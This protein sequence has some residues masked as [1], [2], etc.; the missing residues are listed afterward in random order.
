VSVCVNAGFIASGWVWLYEPVLRRRSERLYPGDWWTCSQF[1]VT[2]E[3][4][5]VLLWAWQEVKGEGMSVNEVCGRRSCVRFG[6]EEAVWFKWDC[7]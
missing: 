3:P 2:F 4:R 5:Q 1:G 7:L 6:L